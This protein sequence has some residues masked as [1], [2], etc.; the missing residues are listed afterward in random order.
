LI[1]FTLNTSQI[2]QRSTQSG[3]SLNVGNLLNNQAN[4]G[5]QTCIHMNRI[6]K[7][8]RPTINAN[9]RV[10]LRQD[11]HASFVQVGQTNLFF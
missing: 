4:R 7:D 3:L 11:N 6:S 2:P 8:T 10:R 9:G 5:S 1:D